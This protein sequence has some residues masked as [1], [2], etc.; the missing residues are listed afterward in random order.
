MTTFALHV[1]RM[2]IGFVQEVA[3]QLFHACLLISRFCALEAYQHGRPQ[4][5][6]PAQ[7][8]ASVHEKCRRAAGPRRRRG[9]TLPQPNPVAALSCALQAHSSPDNKVR[10]PLA[11]FTEAQCSAL[12]EYLYSQGVPSKGTPFKNHDAAALDAA[13][14]VARFAHTYDAP[15]AFRHVEAHLI[16]FM[17]VRFQSIPC[18]GMTGETREETVLGWALMAD[19]FDMDLFCGHCERD[20]MIHWGCFLDKPGLTDQLGSSALQRIAKGLYKILR[21]SLWQQLLGSK[22]LISWCA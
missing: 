11:G 9:H 8:L 17:D 19:K 1:P 2:L 6:V 12:L 14:A 7:C 20:M 13:D 10:I 18:A 3:T 22:G 4:A 16:A 21:V 15:H 5:G